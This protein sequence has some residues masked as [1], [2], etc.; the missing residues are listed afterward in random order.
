MPK[1]R[2]LEPAFSWGD[3]RRPDVPWHDMVIY[4][5]HV[6]GFSMLH[7]DI[8]EPLRGT[9][10]GL[11]SAPAI[12]YLKRLGITT[13]E[14]MPV[15]AYINDR[16]LAE[17]GLQNYWGYNTLGFFAPEMR[18]SCSEKVKEFKTMVK[19][20]HSAG[21][22]V[23]LDVVYNH[24]C[25]GNEL[26]PTLSLRG[27]DNASYY[28]LSSDNP[29]FYA[30]YTGCGNTV[31]LEHPQRAADGDGLAAL[32]GRGDARRRLPLRPRLGAGARERHRSSTWAASST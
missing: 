8:P 5:M 2:V 4:E 19:T 31:N 30:D 15:H 7:P 20:L 16:R 26:G 23:I 32:L 17:K 25:E 1:C 21:I 18:Y 6:R 12:I 27:I 28:M 10:A 29:R 9:Y 13:V 24:T 3:D 11:A 22:E 14:L